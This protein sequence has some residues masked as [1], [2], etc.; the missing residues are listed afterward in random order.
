MQLLRDAN[1][2]CVIHDI[3]LFR[4]RFCHEIF[5]P[6]LQFPALF[7]LKYILGRKEMA[8]QA[9]IFRVV[10]FFFSTKMRTLFIL[11]LIKTSTTRIKEEREVSQR[12]M[13]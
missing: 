8:I 11:L 6:V 1:A 13:Q 7:Y 10:C 3:L 5:F 4:G 12:K 9:N 2:S